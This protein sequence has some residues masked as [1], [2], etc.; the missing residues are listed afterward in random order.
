MKNENEKE[1][2][3]WKWKRKWKRKWEKCFGGNLAVGVPKV[4]WRVENM[5]FK[6]GRQEGREGHWWG[7]GN[8]KWG[9]AG[10]KGKKQKMK[11][12]KEN[13]GWGPAV[14]VPKML[15]RVEN[16]K[17]IQSGGWQGG[18]KKGGGG[19]WGEVRKK[20]RGRGEVA[21]QCHHAEKPT[22]WRSI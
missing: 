12:K 8:P 15:W 10:E 14:G 17:L 16:T 2:E 22:L 4:L 7:L 11:M 1:N 6:R 13:V 18:K 19:E 5:K 21:K 9:G 20:R 3:K